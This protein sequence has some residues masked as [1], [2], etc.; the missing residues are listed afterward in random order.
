MSHLREIVE[1]DGVI[2]EKEARELEHL[3]NILIANGE[4]TRITTLLES[5]KETVS[6][7][8]R[9]SSNMAISVA[10]K[11]TKTLGTGFD[12]LSRLVTRSKEPAST[13]TAHGAEDGSER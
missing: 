5:T 11:S 8:V 7:A 13:E 10:E 2:H 4:K 6:N 9:T 12:R 1:A 3:S